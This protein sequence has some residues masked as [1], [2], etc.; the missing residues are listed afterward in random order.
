MMLRFPPS[1]LYSPSKTLMAFAKALGATK[2]K[3]G[4]L[5][6]YTLGLGKGYGKVADPPEAASI[7]RRQDVQSK[8]DVPGAKAVKMR[9]G[10][11]KVKG[12]KAMGKTNPMGDMHGMLENWPDTDFPRPCEGDC[13]II[14]MRA[15]LEYPDG[16]EANVDTGL[17]LHHSVTVL[18]GPG[19]S[20]PTC[21]QFEVSIP[22][23]GINTT[24]HTS[25]R[26]FASGNERVPVI[27]ADMGAKDSGYRLR[28]EDKLGTLIDLA[29]MNED[30]K[31]VYYTMVWDYVPGHPLKNDVSMAWND[32]RNCGVSEANPPEK[33]TKFTL[34]DTWTSTV[35][36]EIIGAFGHLH[37]GGV[38]TILTADGANVCTS[39]ASY[40]SKPGFTSMPHKMTPGP[41]AIRFSAPKARAEKEVEKFNLAKRKSRTVLMPPEKRISDMSICFGDKLPIKQIKKGQMWKI[42]A[43]YDFDSFGGM[44]GDDGLWEK[45]MGISYVYYKKPV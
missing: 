39:K 45:V 26:I 18:T 30:D 35:D 28:A 41:S 1:L 15:A 43:V 20:D 16:K 21:S 31:T 2:T 42:E 12:V 6:D 10:P 17:M 24:A 4:G 33:K 23:V 25:E 29:N 13:T 3:A 5:P 40:G 37:D 8:I 38:S 27:F 9:Y 44:K 11:Y 36:A 19:R 32:V 22:H 14:G 7:P 34:D